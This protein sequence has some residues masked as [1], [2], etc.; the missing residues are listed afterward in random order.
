[1][2]GDATADLLAVTGHAPVLHSPWNDDPYSSAWSHITSTALF[3]E[4]YAE[5]LSRY[6]YLDAYTESLRNTAIATTPG[7]DRLLLSGR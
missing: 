7:V 4:K 6:G 2:D 3:E 1:V 5:H